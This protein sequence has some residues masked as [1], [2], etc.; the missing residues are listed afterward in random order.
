MDAAMAWHNSMSDSFRK[1]WETT[2][3]PIWVWRAMTR[4]NSLCAYASAACPELRGRDFIGGIPDWCVPYLLQSAFRVE[5]LAGLRDFRTSRAAD[6]REGET[7][8]LS[9]K[10]SSERLPAALG[11]ARPGWNAFG[12]YAGEALPRM[13]LDVMDIE[14][15]AGKPNTMTLDTIKDAMGWGD[16]RNARRKIARLRG[17]AKPKGIV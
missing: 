16:D 2:Q 13:M 5:A 14:R 10:Q 3:N 1:N 12:E 4:L 9:P 8:P 15:G 11:F 17:R 6:Q 7:P